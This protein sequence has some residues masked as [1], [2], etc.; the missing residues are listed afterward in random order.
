MPEGWYEDTDPAALRV[1]LRL[2]REMTPGEKIARI[3]EMAEFQEG[4]QHASVRA[5]YPNASDREVFLRVASRRLRRETM[6]QV[7]NWDPDLHP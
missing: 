7:F 1:F 6:K 4:L 5:L 3:F 2:H